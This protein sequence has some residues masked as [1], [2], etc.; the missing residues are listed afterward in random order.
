MPPSMVPSG[1]PVATGVRVLIPNG[2]PDEMWFTLRNVNSVM[3]ASA[4]TSVMRSSTG[5]GSLRRFTDRVAARLIALAGLGATVITGPASSGSGE[6][7]TLSSSEPSRPRVER[8]ELAPGAPLLQLVDENV[9]SAQRPNIDTV[10]SGPE[11]HLCAPN[12]S[13]GTFGERRLYLQHRNDICRAA[14]EFRISP[15]LIAITVQ[16]EGADRS[17]FSSSSAGKRAEYEAWRRG[18]N[19][20]VGNGQMR[21]DVAQD[22]VRRYH[23]YS[24]MTEGE[25]ARRL[26]WDSPWAIRMVAAELYFL[27]TTLGLRDREAFITYAFGQKQIGRLQGTNFDGEEARSRGE[28][29]DK[30]LDEISEHRGYGPDAFIK[31]SSFLVTQDATRPSS[32][33]QISI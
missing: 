24:G 8:S 26:I 3:T 25:A 12:A 16:H 4:Q 1:P 19:D 32:S 15:T 11:D 27:K 13:Q 33:D 7:K 28:K 31:P 22:L 6:S 20:T 23:G 5:V 9:I 10:A 2:I 18:V 29:Y 21:P 30:L 14:Y 17:W